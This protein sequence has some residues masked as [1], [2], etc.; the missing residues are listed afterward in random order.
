[1]DPFEGYGVFTLPSHTVEMSAI[2][3]AMQR[4]ADEVGLGD[5]FQITIGNDTVPFI[6]DLEFDA[7]AKSFPKAPHTDLET[8][9][10]ESLLVFQQ[11]VA[12]GWLTP[13]NVA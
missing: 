13:A 6:C 2:V 3:A 5:Q 9:F 4:A 8:A 12:R 1:M 10:R 7:F 11:Q